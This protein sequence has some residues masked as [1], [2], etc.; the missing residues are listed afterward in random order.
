MSPN[1]AR[2]FSLFL[3]SLYSFPMLV[4]CKSISSS[5]LLS[6]L[7]LGLATK[8]MTTMEKIEICEDVKWSWINQPIDN[9]TY[10]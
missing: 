5:G 2:R 9:C 3:F 6:L 4:S 8:K 1:G 10:Q 7:N